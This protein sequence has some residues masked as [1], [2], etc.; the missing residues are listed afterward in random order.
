MVWRQNKG[1]H[2]QVFASITRKCRVY[3]IGDERPFMTIRQLTDM[4]LH[5][6]QESC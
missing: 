1:D 5:Y 3:L 2:M 4:T 6:K